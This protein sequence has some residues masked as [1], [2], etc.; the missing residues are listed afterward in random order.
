MTIRDWSLITGRGGYKTGEG[1]CEIL[2][3]RK[4]GHKE[5]LAMVK[6]GGRQTSFGVVFTQQL[7][8]LAIL[9]GGGGGTKCSH[10][11]GGGAKSFTLS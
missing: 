2:P 1:A 11:T 5:V 9:K 3:L 6:G 8:V 10:S 4:G 7:E